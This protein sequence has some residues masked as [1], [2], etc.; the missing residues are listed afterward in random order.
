MAGNYVI[1]TMTDTDSEMAIEWAASEGW[2]PG[3]NDAACFYQTD[4]AGFLIGKLD[5]EP[6]SVIS[7]VRYG[8][9][10]GFIGM[11]IVKPAY[12][13]RGFGIK[14]WNAAIEI[15]NGRTLGLD[16]VVD[17]QENYKLSGFHLAYRNIRFEGQ[18]RQGSAL[19][20]VKLADLNTV[21]FDTINSY[22]RAFFPEDRS[23][24][25]RMWVG[26]PGISGFAAYVV[27]TLGGY[28]VIR[29]CRSGY[30]VG[31]LFADTPDLARSLLSAMLSTTTDGAA[32]YLDVPEPNELAVD[33]AES[34][35]MTVVFETA[36]M[37][38]GS[39]PD[40]PVHKVFGVTTF[41]LG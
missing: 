20:G 38:T 1:N 24:F 21:P 10:F 33:L 9:S 41:E 13:G 5:G 39:T 6:V 32:F 14:I 27:D 34:L 8:E 35:G 23:R 19:D 11:Y 30:K 25:L 17:Q 36:R 26:Q 37:Y 3:I 40:L 16:G 28:G 12:R 15:L 31:P 29:P 2:N 18:N 22:D 7:A 4:P